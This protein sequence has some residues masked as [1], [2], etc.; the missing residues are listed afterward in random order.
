MA[1]L[2]VDCNNNR[3]LYSFYNH[4]IYKKL[5]GIDIK[6]QKS[7][8]F[9]QMNIH[10]IQTPNYESDAQIERRLVYDKVIKTPTE[11]DS[12]T[13]YNDLSCFKI[14]KKYLF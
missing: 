1:I 14:R 4:R 9:C 11:L 10:G 8:K 12:H 3:K 5:K 2:L 13:V 7:F 6:Y